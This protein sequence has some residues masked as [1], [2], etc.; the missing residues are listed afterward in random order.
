VAGFWRALFGFGDKQQSGYVSD[1]DV[2]PLTNIPPPK[3]NKIP[4]S[5]TMD[6]LF[7]S[8][9]RTP[10]NKWRQLG[11]LQRVAGTSFRL[12]EAREFCS[13]AIWASKRGTPVHLELVPDPT[14]HYDKNAIKVMGVLPEKQ[15]FV[16]YVPKEE[17]RILTEIR[18]DTQDGPAGPM[19]L[20]AELYRVASEHD[21]VAIDFISLEPAAGDPWSKA[22]KES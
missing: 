21:W 22:Q 15:F 11:G 20:G 8:K 12:D 9:P 6:H 10:G 2:Q 14:N 1:D 3:W 16:G 19:P 5:R 17:A 7:Q 18:K 13:E 4:P